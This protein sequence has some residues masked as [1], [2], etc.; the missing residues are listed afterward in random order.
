M[1]GA[2]TV[3]QVILGVFLMALILLQ[4]KGTGLG[5]VFGGDNS[6]FRTRRGVEQVLF[7]FTIGIAT[8]FLV[9]SLIVVS[10]FVA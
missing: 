7:N 1:R 9:D 2:F 10:K 5:S 3:V 8:A 6:V 4:S